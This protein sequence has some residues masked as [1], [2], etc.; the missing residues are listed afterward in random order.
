MAAHGLNPNRGVQPGPHTRHSI[1]HVHP[2]AATMH[3]DSQMP[4][5]SPLTF[6][7]HLPCTQ[8]PLYSARRAALEVGEA[9]KTR[10]SIRLAYKPVCGLPSAQL[11]L[12]SLGGLLG[13]SAAASA[14]AAVLPPSMD[15]GRATQLAS[16]VGGWIGLLQLA[17]V[18]SRPIGW[19]R[20]CGTQRRDGFRSTLAASGTPC[21]C[22]ACGRGC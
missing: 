14:A 18:R 15:A 17:P 4:V 13:D 6:V 19:P 9:L 22:S 2:C 8:P 3:E 7:L 16:R 5:P 21:W 11:V 12:D 20:Q 1:E 10:R